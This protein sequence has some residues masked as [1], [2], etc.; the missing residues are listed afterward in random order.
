MSFLLLKNSFLQDNFLLNGCSFFRH[1]SFL[2]V[3][4]NIH[5]A[6]VKKVYASS[7][8]G[9]SLSVCLTSLGDNPAKIWLGQKNLFG[10][11]Q[12]AQGV[13]VHN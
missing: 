13:L 9:E 8:G 12:N 7:N 4:N 10:Q 6:F 3:L 5:P 2:Q 11:I 1:H